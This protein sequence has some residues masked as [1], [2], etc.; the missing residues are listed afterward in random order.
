MNTALISVAALGLL[1]ALA[2]VAQASDFT[3]SEENYHYGMALEVAEVIS[4]T[5]QP[6]SKNQISQVQ[7]LYLDHNDQV[8]CVTYEKQRANEHTEN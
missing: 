1:G 4:I 2:S 3:P 6:G 7:M 8:R 5:E